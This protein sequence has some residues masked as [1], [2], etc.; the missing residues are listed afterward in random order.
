MKN[1]EPKLC[2]NCKFYQPSN[3][4]Y[5]FAVCTHPILD[6]YCDPVSGERNSFCK[7][8]RK[9]SV[10]DGGCG[11]EAHYYEKRLS[12]WEKLWNK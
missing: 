6:E 11:K 8:L 2:K 7:I 9:W 10:D 3:I 4:H 5:E 1:T 12:W